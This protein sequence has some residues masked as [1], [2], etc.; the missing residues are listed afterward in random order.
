MLMPERLKK[1]DFVGLVCPSSPISPE[2]VLACKASI[3]DMGYQVRVG[4]ACFETMHGYL[5]GSAEHRARDLNLMFA[6]PKIKAIFCIRGG[7]GSSQIMELIDYDMIARN[8]KIFV[9]YS[10]ITNLNVAF[11]TLSNMVTFHGPMVSSNMLEHYDDYTKSCFEAAINMDTELYLHNPEL[12]PM[13]ILV[14][15]TCQGTVVGG[16]LA[17][18]IN[19]LGTFYAPD[20]HGKVL[21]IE[22]IY[23]SI[24]RI[25]RMLDQLRLLHVFD[26]VVGIL[27][28]DF[29]DCEKEDNDTYSV[30]DFMEEYFT[31]MRI[32]V[33]SNIKCGHCFPTATI[34]LGTTCFVNTKEQIV[35][36]INK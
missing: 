5:A 1:G 12:E 7:N 17:L 8:P 36:F 20:F 13:K 26:E 24:P 15:G 35:K 30:D 4:K 3:E 6:D 16:N 19:L 27:I 9:G 34:P 22:D 25:H 31:S 10:D 11:C 2:R 18:I 28:G 33:I 14:P 29:S 23:E 21:F 32:P